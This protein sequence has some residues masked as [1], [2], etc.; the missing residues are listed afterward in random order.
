MRESHLARYK[1][2]S[3][4]GYL[5]Y[6][7]R[8]SRSLSRPKAEQVREDYVHLI[9]KREKLENT[10][11]TCEWRSRESSRV[12]KNFDFC[13]CELTRLPLFDSEKI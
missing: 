12:E 2:K 8:E 6:L 11:P 3:N 13:A 7:V 5:S 1:S 10:A 4:L 9:E